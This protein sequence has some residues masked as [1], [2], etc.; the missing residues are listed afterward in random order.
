VVDRAGFA[1][2]SVLESGTKFTQ[3]HIFSARAFYGTTAAIALMGAAAETL[4]SKEAIV[5]V[6]F[7]RVHTACFIQFLAF[8]FIISIWILHEHYFKLLKLAVDRQRDIEGKE[9][10]IQGKTVLRLGTG[11]TRK[12][13]LEKY[14][15]RYKRLVGKFIYAPWNILFVILLALAIGLAAAYFTM[16]TN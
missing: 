10:L 7:C 12:K 6:L 15:N 4:R 9:L 2:F 5:G 16:P 13:F 1:P 3:V 11:I 14:D 8:V